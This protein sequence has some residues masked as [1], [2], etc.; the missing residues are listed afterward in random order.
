MQR[1]LCFDDFRSGDDID[2]QTCLN[3]TLLGE[4]NF[5]KSGHKLEFTQS[6]SVFFLAHSC[7]RKRYLSYLQ[8]ATL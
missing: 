5:C 7:D 2:A 8:K 1:I 4:R 6:C 3:E